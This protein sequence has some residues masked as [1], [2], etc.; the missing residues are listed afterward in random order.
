M[1]I[2]NVILDLLGFSSDYGQEENTI[3]EQHIGETNRKNHQ[4]EY[5]QYGDGFRK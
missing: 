3:E 1:Y 2:S 5:P 4:K